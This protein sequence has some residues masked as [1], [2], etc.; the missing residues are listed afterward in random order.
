M[1]DQHDHR[2]SYRWHLS[3]TL[4]SLASSDNDPDDDR[5]D[6]FE[7]WMGRSEIAKASRRSLHFTA[8]T[9]AR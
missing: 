3:A 7:N 2:L 4:F 6:R 1:I 8:T 5:V 9:G